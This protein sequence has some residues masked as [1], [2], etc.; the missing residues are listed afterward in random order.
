MQ[1]YP[2]H[3]VSLSQPG[4][5]RLRRVSVWI[6]TESRTRSNTN[7]FIN[8]RKRSGITMNTTTFILIT[9]AMAAATFIIRFL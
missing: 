9:L 7:W 5:R 8:R 6:S 1:N 2:T 4:C 3:L